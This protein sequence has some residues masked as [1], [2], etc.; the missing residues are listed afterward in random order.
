MRNAI[1]NNG[2]VGSGVRA[3][4]GRGVLS[5]KVVW[6]MARNKFFWGGRIEGLLLKVS[7]D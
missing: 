6:V 4:V 3:R 2:L 5:T 1:D 7:S